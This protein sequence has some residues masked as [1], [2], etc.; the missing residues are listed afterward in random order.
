MYVK[1]THFVKHKM[2][3]GGPFCEIFLI[4]V[5]ILICEIQWDTHGFLVT[6]AST[7]VHSPSPSPY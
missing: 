2:Y 3:S 4:S 6:E 1:N 5:N 7:I